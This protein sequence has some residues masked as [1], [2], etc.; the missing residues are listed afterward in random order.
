MKRS[1]FINGNSYDNKITDMR[2]KKSDITWYRSCGE[3]RVMFGSPEE[4]GYTSY[5]NGTLSEFEA[6]LFSDENERRDGRIEA[7]L[8]VEESVIGHGLPDIQDAIVRLESG[9]DL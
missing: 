5:F 4:T 9:G 6:L 2:Y 8:W 7:L 1:D 3:N